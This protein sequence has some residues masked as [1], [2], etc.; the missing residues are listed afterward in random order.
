MK[1]RWYF[2][3]PPNFCPFSWLISEGVLFWCKKSFQQPV[4]VCHFSRLYSGE[5][6]PLTTPAWLPAST[7]NV[8]NSSSCVPCISESGR[9][10]YWRLKKMP[11][12]FR[13]LVCQ[14]AVSVATLWR[15]FFAQY[16]SLVKLSKKYPAKRQFSWLY[17]GGV[18]RWAEKLLSNCR[19]QPFPWLLYEG[20]FV[21]VPFH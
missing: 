10:H 9:V 6:L 1:I 11:R 19:K 3:K 14:N 7:E 15:D 21:P 17:Y 5:G 20:H 16:K 12:F 2:F 4:A 18:L 8:R 13:K